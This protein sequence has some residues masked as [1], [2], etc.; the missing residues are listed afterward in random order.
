MDINEINT[1]IKWL[2]NSELVSDWYHTFNE[3]YSHRIALF[4]VLCNHLYLYSDRGS[5]DVWKARFHSDGTMF[6]W[7]FIAGIWQEKWATLTYHL[8]ISHWDKMY[9]PEISKAPEWDGHTSDDVINL[10]Y[11]I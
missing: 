10:L 5:S 11:E 4:I 9:V 1:A 6:D 7:W 2:Q 8:P 3:L